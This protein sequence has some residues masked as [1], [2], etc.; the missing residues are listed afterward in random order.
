MDLNHRKMLRSKMVQSHISK[1]REDQ[2]FSKVEQDIR[3]HFK[4]QHR[5]KSLNKGSKI[6]KQTIRIGNIRMGK[7]WKKNLEIRL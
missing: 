6:I 4:I 5:N 2:E 7:I 3:S 1:I